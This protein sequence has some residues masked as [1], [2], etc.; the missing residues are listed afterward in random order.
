MIFNLQAGEV[1]TLPIVSDKYPEDI[2]VKAEENAVFSAVIEK[3][4]IPTEYTYKWYVNDSLVADVTTSSYTRKTD[5][6]RGVYSVYCEITNKA[7][8]V[9]TRTATLTVNAL[10]KLDSDKPENVTANLGSSKTLSVSITEHGYPES[11]TYQWYKNGAKI[12]GATSPSYTFTPTTIGSTKFYCEV[13]NIAGTATTRTATVTASTGYLYQSG[14]LNTTLIGGMSL[15]IITGSDDIFDIN[16][17]KTNIYM[18]KGGKGDGGPKYSGVYFTN[19]AIDLTNVKKITINVTSHGGDTYWSDVDLITA[20]SKTRT[21]SPTAKK[22]L[23]TVGTHSLDVSALTGNQYIG[24]W[25]QGK[26]ACFTKFTEL[27]IS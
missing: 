2:T 10:P 26:G 5:A 4:G 20:K 9:K 19:K 21:F 13:T 18:Y 15:V 8:S 7:G 17:N 12:S 16:I 25:L 14:S 1:K 22:S 27:K 24:I 23:E 11:Y 3:D 6:D